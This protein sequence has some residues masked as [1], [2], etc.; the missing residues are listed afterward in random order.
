MRYAGLRSIV[1]NHV[2]FQQ[3]S[4]RFVWLY[5]C[6]RNSHAF[7]SF[8]DERL[9]WIRSGIHSKEAFER[10]AETG[11]T[12]E[13]RIQTEKEYGVGGVPYLRLSRSSPP[14]H[15]GPGVDATMTGPGLVGVKP[16][17]RLTD[18]GLAKTRTS[19]RVWPGFPYYLLSNYVRTGKD[20]SWAS[21]RV[22]AQQ[23]R[24][25]TLEVTIERRNFS[26]FLFWNWRN[27]RF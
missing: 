6:S 10:S 21:I 14:E 19:G 16:A 2:S 25:K 3:R 23:C 15:C 20:F 9:S 11:S 7:D 5:W 13:K 1:I 26:S 22:V 4:F 8:A 18:P 17:I 12:E 27:W 24:S